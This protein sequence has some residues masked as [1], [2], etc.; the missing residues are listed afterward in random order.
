MQ[1]INVEKIKSNRKIMLLLLFLFGLPALISFA[2]Y[3]TAWR[4]ATTVNHGKLIL[5]ARSIEDRAM[6]T[7]DG[8]PV[9]FADLRGKWTMVYF[10]RA[11]CLENCVS[12]LYFMRQTHASLGKNYDRVQRLFILTDEKSDA[13]LKSKLTEYEGMLVWKST[14]PEIAK[15][16]NEFGID[17]QEDSTNSGI[18]LLDQQGNLMMRYNLGAEPAGVRKDLERLLKYSGDK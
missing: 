8:K 15:L 16:Q 3:F 5:P 10:D 6:L 14:K 4:P 9:K 11:E 12:Q 17:T 1:S 13:N 18:Y 2:M 7:M